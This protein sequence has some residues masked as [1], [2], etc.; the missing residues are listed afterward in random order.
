[1][2]GAHD[3]HQPR[4]ETRPLPLLASPLPSKA[5]E[6]LTLSRSFDQFQKLSASHPPPRPLRFFDLAIAA[7]PSSA[8][9]QT[10]RA[11]FPGPPATEEGDPESACA[12]SSVPSASSLSSCS[13]P[14]RRERR[15]KGRAHAMD[16]SSKRTDARA[17][18]SSRGRR[19]RATHASRCA[20]CGWSSSH[21]ATRMWFE[22]CGER[23]HD[24]CCFGK[25]A[26]KAAAT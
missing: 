13:S 11:G 16:A 20:C 15:T 8:L 3:I 17:R 21:P 5:R 6:A 10:R 2:T 24:T 25:Q 19:C 12:L 26:A 7:S 9:A 14:S 4:T 22:Q 23:N 18:E 1:M